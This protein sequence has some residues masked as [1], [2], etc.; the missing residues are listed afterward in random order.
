MIRAK[1]YSADEISEMSGVSKDQVEELIDDVNKED[2]T[3][4]I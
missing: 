1:K 2:C 3:S 4:T